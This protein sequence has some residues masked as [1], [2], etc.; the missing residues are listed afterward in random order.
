MQV[1]PGSDSFRLTTSTDL[2]KLDP[3]KTMSLV[4]PLNKKE[5][6][7]FTLMKI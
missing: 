7:V 2:V 5:I 6:R 1:F 4:K 3:E